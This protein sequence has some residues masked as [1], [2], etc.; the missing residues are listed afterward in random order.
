MA[1]PKADKVEKPPRLPA[2]MITT[3]KAIVSD[4]NGDLWLLNANLGTFKR[5]VHES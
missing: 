5:L 4:R 3:D 2:G 1:K